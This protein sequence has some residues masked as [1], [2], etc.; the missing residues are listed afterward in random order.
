MDINQINKA[1]LEYIK[2]LKKKDI[3]EFLIKCDNAFFN[4][5]KTLISDDIYDIIKDYIRTKYPK[6]SYLKRIGAD[7]ENKVLLPIYM[8]SQNKIKDNQEEITKYSKKYKAPYIISH[9]LDGVSC[10]IQYKTNGET[11]IYT[12]GDGT[13]GQNIS[14]IIDYVKGIPKILKNTNE[15]VL[16]RGELII[17]RNNWEKIKDLGAN[18][19][20]VVAGAVNS[21]IINKNI[22]SNIEFVAYELINPKHTTIDG[23]KHMKEFGLNVVK[24]AIENIINLEVLSKYLIEWREKGL[25]EIDG[26]IIK[27]NGIYNIVK[28]KNPEN[29]FAFKSVHTHEQI[30]VIVTEILWNVSKD[31]YIKPIIKFNEIDLNGV[32]IKQASGFNASFITKNKLG[33]GSR[34]IIIRSGDV[35]PHILE[36]LTPSATG[37]PDMP[38]IPYIWNDTHVDIMLSSDEKNRD[39]DIKEFVYFMKA[40]DIQGVGPGIITK[41]YD[42][43]FDTIKKIFNIK[44]DDIIKI[45]G[46]KEKSA[47]NVLNGLS[48]IHSIDCL[49]LMDASNVFGRGYGERKLKMITDKFPCLLNFDKVNREKSLKLTVSDLITTDGI[50]EIS[51]KL[52]IDN[53]PKF[54]EFYDDLNI[55][56]NSPIEVVENKIIANNSNINGKGFL[57][58]GF[59]SKEHE[60]MITDLGGLIK[61]SISKS[62][63][64]LIVANKDTDNTKVKKALELGIKII[65]IKDLEKLLF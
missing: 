55:K 41:L 61:T 33:A 39:H 59:R 56:C 29:S 51:A 5:G 63:D 28:N 10:L 14:H 20:N 43:G 8:G 12:R 9:K 7:L 57:F 23:L 36:V 58:T 60:K 32:K 15:E 47:N 27:D 50:A 46:F 16:I 19:R 54:Y 35:I 34:V 22:M 45:D 42:S 25:Y 17:S 6:D 64:Y 1:P 37:S 49:N 62:L 13:Y 26:I 2:N 65:D 31:K 30:E 11:N 52:F 38:K 40:L 3:I 21:K 24:Y 4:T 48:K 18:A 44:Y 53:L